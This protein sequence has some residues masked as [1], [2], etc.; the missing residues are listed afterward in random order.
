M[1]VNVENL[2]QDLINYYGAASTC[3]PIF[4]AAVAEIE[5]ATPSRIIEIA[6]TTNINLNNY[7]SNEN[8]NTYTKRRKK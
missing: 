1:T 5:S 3:N 4:L 6:S 2:R 7:Q 8:N